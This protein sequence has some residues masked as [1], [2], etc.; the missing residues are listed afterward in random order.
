MIPARLPASAVDDFAAFL[1]WCQSSHHRRT[2]L[3]NY[4]NN[5]YSRD[6]WF[7]LYHSFY[8]LIYSLKTEILGFASSDSAKKKIRAFHPIKLGVWSWDFGIQSLLIPKIP[9]RI[10]L[11]S[12]AW[13]R[14]QKQEKPETRNKKPETFS[15][16]KEKT[17][18]KIKSKFASL[19]WAWSSRPSAREPYG[20]KYEALRSKTKTL[21]RKAR[22]IGMAR[23]LP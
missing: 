16:R 2:T 7:I 3:R 1:Q 21:L 23:C 4:L 14:R 13:C 11:V 20:G 10:S 12:P 22:V 8:S 9:A 6:S 15:N 19:R 18:N 17:M 5:L